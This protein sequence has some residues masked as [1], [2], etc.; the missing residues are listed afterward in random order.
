MGFV[1]LPPNVYPSRKRWVVRK[2]VNGQMYYKSFDNVFDAIKHR[3]EMEKCNWSIP[4]LSEDEILALKQK[5]YYIRVCLDYSHRWYKIKKKGGGCL[6]KTKDI[7]EALYYRDLY[8]ESDLDVSEIPKIED[9]DLVTGNPYLTDG[10]KVPLPDRLILDT[11]VS[12]RGRGKIVKKSVSSYS[13]YL[14]RKHVCSCR[15]YEQAFYLKQEMNK[16]DWNLDELQRILDDYPIYYTWLLR[17]YMYVTWD[18]R[19]KNW[20]VSIPKDKSDDGKLQH[21][22]FSKIEDALYERD[23]LVEHDW[24]YDLLVE[25]I[26]DFENPYYDMELPPYPERKIRNISPRKSHDKEFLQLAEILREEPNITVEDWASRIGTTGQTL[27]NWFREYETT[28]PEFKK[29]VL[30]GKNPCDVFKQKELIYTPDLSKSKSSNFRNYVH[31][32][33]KRKSKWIV[34]RN[35]VYYG[36]YSTKEVADEVVKELEKVDWDKSE[37][38][39]IKERL[40]IRKHIHDMMYIYKTKKHLNSWQIR[41]KKKGRN[42]GYG[43]Y[44]DI[45]FAKLI[46]DILVGINFKCDDLDKLRRFG[47]WVVYSK[48]LYYGNMFGGVRL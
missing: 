15:T 48:G 14:G 19:Q 44:R 21:I 42:I 33:S 35:D 34:S 6:D 4:D 20:L 36:C 39:N 45:E 47:E 17:F 22:R 41:K 31:Y 37:L 18:S 29:V 12:K 3:N 32:A 2:S 26:N 13:V 1:N 25:L 16:I 43:V 28:T 8:S 11:S 30:E 27:R 24:D 38:D 7:Y 23:F 46:R 9:C 5:D 40:G 10:L